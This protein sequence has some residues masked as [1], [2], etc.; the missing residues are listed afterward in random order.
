MVRVTNWEC[1][2]PGSNLGPG[3]TCTKAS[4]SANILKSRAELPLPCG[5]ETATASSAT[6]SKLRN[7]C[8]QL[9]YSATATHLIENVFFFNYRCITICIYRHKSRI[10]P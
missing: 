4:L 6:F 9:H 5:A 7:Y 8:W 10:C 2:G 3:S 1:T